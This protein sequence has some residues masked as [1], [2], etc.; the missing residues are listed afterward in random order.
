MRSSLVSVRAAR[1]WSQPGISAV[2][3][4]MTPVPIELP[5]PQEPE[6]AGVQRPA[7]GTAGGTAPTLGLAAPLQLLRAALERLLKKKI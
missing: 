1:L 2:C 3:R 6:L 5:K 7:T 4:A